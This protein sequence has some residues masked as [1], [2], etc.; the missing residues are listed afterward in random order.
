L[1]WKKKEI[2][3]KANKRG[4]SLIT[5]EI[6]K[7]LPFIE[8]YNIGILHLFIKHTSAS[9]TI[10]ENCDSTV[11][12]DLK[13]HFDKMVPEQQKYYTHI[14]EGPDDMPAHIKSSI[15]GNNLNIPISNGKLDLGIW[16]GIYL[17]EHRNNP[18]I[19]IITA[20][21]NGEIY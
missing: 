10:N 9:I 21:I 8:N 18:P 16:Q 4:F 19:R 17:C 15:I 5:K 6:I 2:S 1:N 11:R 14:F 12:N 3:I 7:Q 13:T 20:T